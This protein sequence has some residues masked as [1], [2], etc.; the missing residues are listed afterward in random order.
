MNIILS[1]RLDTLTE[2]I[3]NKKNWII[4]ILIVQNASKKKKYEGNSRI[5]SIFTLNELQESNDFTYFD[6]DLA[7]KMKHVQTIN[8][9]GLRRILDDYQYSRYVHFSSLAKINKIFVE[10]GKID[11]CIINEPIH[12]FASDALLAEMAKLN[13]IPVFNF[14][15]QTNNKFCINMDVINGN[16]LRLS[17]KSSFTKDD[18]ERAA[19]WMEYLSNE[20][21]KNSKLKEWILSIG[22]MLLFRTIWCLINRRKSMVIN[23]AKFSL[24]NYYKSWINIWFMRRYINRRYKKFNNG[25]PYVVYFLHFEPEAIVSNY[26]ETMDSQLVIIN[27]IASLL[28]AGWKLYVKEHPDTYKLNRETFDYFVPTY[29]TFQT[30]FFFD[31]IISAP[32]TY[33]VDYR[34]PASELINDAKAVASICGTVLLEAITKNKPILEFANGNK[35]IISMLKDVFAIQSYKDLYMAMQKIESGFVPQYTDVEDVYNSFLLPMSTDGYSRG[36]DEIENKL[37]DE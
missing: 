37:M 14:T 3:L 35:Y 20:P 30:K 8:D 5:K 32:N 12:G 9:A 34:I 1:D 17:D 28:P 26:S 21:I 6:F 16:L 4:S 25:D 23:F 15:V 33:L 2:L 19:H 31:K 22:G 18:I 11:V 27:M 36:I 7:K 10:S 24:W 29:K 13:N